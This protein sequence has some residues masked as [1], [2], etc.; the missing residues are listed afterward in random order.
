MKIEIRERDGDG[1]VTVESTN[2]R[3]QVA[4]ESKKRVVVDAREV[5]AALD[6]CS[7]NPASE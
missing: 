6:A 1:T 7:R 3:G 2:K 5:K 4:I